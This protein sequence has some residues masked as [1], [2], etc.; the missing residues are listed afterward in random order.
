MKYKAVF[1]TGLCAAAA[2][3]MMFAAAGAALTPESAAAYQG[4]LNDLAGQYGSVRVR[5]AE[6]ALGGMYLGLTCARLI[7]FDG[8][9][10]P[11]L[12]CAY[13]VP[14]EGSR[15]R[16]VLYTY[17]GGLVKLDIPEAVSNFN[18]DVSPVSRLI[19]GADK[20]YLVDGQEVMNGN[21]VRY[22]TKQGHEMV[23]ALAYVTGWVQGQWICR[24]NGEDM[25]RD[26]LT[27]AL[28]T[29]ALGLTDTEYSYWSTGDGAD[30]TATV[31]PT[32]D[33]LRA[34]TVTQAEP[35]V[36]HIVVNGKRYDLSAYAI[37]G[38]NYL[39]L[40]DFALVLSGTPSQFGVDWDGETR[41][42][43]LTTGRRY[44][45]TGGELGAAPAASAQAERA[46]TALLLD[47][48]TLSPA[49]YIIEQNHYYRLRDLA[50]ALGLSVSWNA[51]A[52]TA[53]LSRS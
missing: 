22:L 11:E 7:D 50:E 46:A 24:L 10:T 51:H 13:G 41:C 34:K 17:D 15:I 35:S 4:V 1:R 36:S 6:N 29:F 39:K 44:I 19:V 40:R 49:T 26:G 43:R 48:R 21:E 45:R 9:G 31:Q 8:D 14:G 33:E 47:G 18:T 37:R 20:A 52:K 38:N 25:T 30:P 23:S 12:Y 28:N 53:T 42:I 27:R 32:L 16:Q 5:P 2:C 3:L